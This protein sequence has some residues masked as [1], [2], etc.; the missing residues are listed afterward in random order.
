MTTRIDFEIAIFESRTYHV[1]FAT[2]IAHITM[3]DFIEKS[4]LKWKPRKWFIRGFIRDGSINANHVLRRTLSLLK[5][6][7]IFFISILWERFLT[8]GT[9]SEC[10]KS[11]RYLLRCHEVFKREIVFPISRRVRIDIRALG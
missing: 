9:D 6:S 8:D 7:E 11:K 10:R 2:I 4:I 1:I 3:Y 5:K